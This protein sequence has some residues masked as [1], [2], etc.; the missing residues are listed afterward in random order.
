M[1][2]PR[3]PSPTWSQDKVEGGHLSMDWGPPDPPQTLAPLHATMPPPT[4]H[5][6]P[7]HVMSSAPGCSPAGGGGEVSIS[8]GGE[9]CCLHPPAHA[10]T[11]SVNIWCI[12][13]LFFRLLYFFADF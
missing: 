7:P 10:L 1:T 2:E 13:R 3:V 9:L 6:P 12:V 4:P 8:G 5:A 11:A